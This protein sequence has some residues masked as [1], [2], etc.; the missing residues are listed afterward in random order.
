MNSNNNNSKSAPKLPSNLVLTA[1]LTG[2]ITIVASLLYFSLSIVALVYRFKCNAKEPENVSGSGLFLDVVY[3]AYIL[4]GG[5]QNAFN[6]EEITQD[7][8]VFVFALITLVVS[9]VSLIAASILISV[10]TTERGIQYLTIVVCGHIG[11]YI[12]SLTVDL[13]VAVHFGMDY[14]HFN[15]L[16]NES[17]PGLSMN[18]MMDLLRLG[19]F[20]LMVI[21]LKGFIVHIINIVLLILL[22][23]YLLQYS[24][25]L[26]KQEHS[27]HKL[28]ALKA[29]DTKR[30]R[31]PQHNHR[32]TYQPPRGQQLNYGYLSDEEPP[33][34]PMRDTTRSDYSGV[35]YDR[36]Y[37]WQHG[38]G[39]SSGRPFS[40]LE[41]AKRQAPA[42]PPPS[43]AVENSWRDPWRSNGPPVPAP[44]YSPTPRR[45]KPA[46][47]SGYM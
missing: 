32:D 29:Y 18:Y 27:I 45:L 43:P 21:S 36:S 33:R 41:E 15:G 13:T 26:D 16:L 4:D 35:G 30:S 28:G 5:C 34:S 46:L 1:V 3:R 47:K 10:V 20:S 6:N 44:D 11:V 31:E 38:P 25:D 22:V 14:S 7:Y 19:A 42:R 12:A 40:Y 9:V 23:V 37:S 39:S 2:S 8:S 17:S 24:S